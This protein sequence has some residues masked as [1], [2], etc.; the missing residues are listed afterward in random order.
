[1]PTRQL[2][3]SSFLGFFD[4]GILEF[5]WEDVALLPM[6]TLAVQNQRVLRQLLQSPVETRFN[7]CGSPFHLEE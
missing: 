6:F 5:S 3:K 7:Y 1:M 4:N 2:N